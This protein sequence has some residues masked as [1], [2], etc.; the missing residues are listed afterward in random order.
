MEP[1]AGEDAANPAAKAGLFKALA[2]WT[3]QATADSAI[4]LPL[5]TIEEMRD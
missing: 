5:Q 3:N 4:L 2:E 1:K